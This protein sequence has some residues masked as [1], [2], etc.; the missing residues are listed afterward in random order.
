MTV[1]GMQFRQVGDECICVVIGE[2]HFAK[3]ANCVQHIECPAS[4]LGLDFTERLHAPELCAHFILRQ[5][6]AFRYND[7][8]RF[9][10]Y[11]VQRNV[12]TNPAGTARRNS[13]RFTLDNG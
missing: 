6:L 4:F 1:T 3:R 8:S 2:F 12:A 9:N 10:R 13:E 7:N 5:N 11:M